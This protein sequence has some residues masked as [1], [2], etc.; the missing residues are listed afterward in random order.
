MLLVHLAFLMHLTHLTHWILRIL[1]ITLKIPEANP[2]LM[3]GLAPSMRKLAPS[4]PGKSM[5]TRVSQF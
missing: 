5:Q 3:A 4:F 2:T 1:P